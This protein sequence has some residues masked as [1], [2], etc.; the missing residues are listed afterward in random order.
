MK[1]TTI[2]ALFV[3]SVLLTW[4][5]AV[6]ENPAYAGT[7]V[8]NPGNVN[9]FQLSSGGEYLDF[10]LMFYTWPTQGVIQGSGWGW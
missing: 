2:A 10:W 1:M 7:S 6:A 9:T 4:V 8:G 3:S 5:V